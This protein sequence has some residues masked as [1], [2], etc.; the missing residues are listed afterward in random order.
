M[1][2]NI[3]ITIST[4][5]IDDNITKE[6]RILEYEE[7]FN[8]IKGFGYFDFYIVETVLSYSD[9]LEKHS[10]NVFYTNVNGKYNNR[11]TNY[12]NSFKK[13]LNESKFNDDDIIVHITGR[14][15]LTDDS[16][17]KNCLKLEKEKIGCFK[18]D[19]HNQCYL[20][21]YGMRFKELKGLLNSINVDYME[22]NMINLEMLFSQNIPE[23]TIMLLDNLGIIGRQ[24]NEK[25][26]NVYGKLKF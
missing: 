7:C 21:L 19:R 6:Q 17:F 26:P 8:I 11:G 15:P 18:K 4:A 10:K 1:D 25:N 20:F 24:S 22:R 16:F 23:D 12:V 5:I 2:N 14:Y 13:F 9:F 3:I